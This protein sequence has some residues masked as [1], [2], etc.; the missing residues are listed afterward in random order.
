MDNPPIA[1]ADIPDDSSHEERRRLIINIL[2]TAT[3][4][5]FNR[6]DN[7]LGELLDYC[8]LANYNDRVTL[9]IC[10]GQL[11]KIRNKE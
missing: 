10:F 5:S 9:G 8:L 3:G 4:I 7:I 1:I 11:W 6:L 2:N